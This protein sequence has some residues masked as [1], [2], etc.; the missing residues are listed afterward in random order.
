M[1]V[2]AAYRTTIYVDNQTLGV[3]LVAQLDAHVT[4]TGMLMMGC[5]H[6]PWKYPSPPPVIHSWPRR[7]HLC[8]V[9]PEMR[10]VCLLRGC[11]DVELGFDHHCDGG[12]EAL[13]GA[14]DHGCATAAVGHDGGLVHSELRRCA[15]G[16]GEGV[17]GHQLPGGRGVGRG[18]TGTREGLEGGQC[19]PGRAD[20]REWGPVWPHGGLLFMGGLRQSSA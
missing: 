17:G 16:P 14:V 9:E 5:L 20:G 3:P 6:G 19:R 1:T 8:I 13:S 7:C 15:R 4:I 2:E 12:G 10:I 11:R 18:A